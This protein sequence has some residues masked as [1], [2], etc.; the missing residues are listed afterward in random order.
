MTSPKHSL[1][2][3]SGDDRGMFL[4]A[5]EFVACSRMQL[6][7]I[8]GTVVGQRMALEP[9]PQ[10]FDRIEVGRVWRQESVEYTGVSLNHET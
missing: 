9:R 7:K 4:C 5:P 8:V 6:G 2:P 1:H 10:I 3:A